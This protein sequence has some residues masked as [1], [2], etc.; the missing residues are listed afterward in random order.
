MEFK[1]RFYNA[2][3]ALL[4]NN[5]IFAEYYKRSTGNR[6]EWKRQANTLQAKEIKDWKTGV[7]TATDPE[8]PRRGDLMRFYQGLLLDNHLASVIDTRILRVQRSSFKLIDDRGTENDALKQLLER[9]WFEDLIR[10]VLMSRFQGATLIEMFDINAETLELERVDE[11]PQ[12]NFIA[13]KGLVIKEEYDDSGADYRTDAF[14]DC[15]FQVGGDWD[16]GMLNQL[17]MIVLAKKLGLGSWMSYV[18]KYGIPPIF[19]ITD[20]MD[21]GRRDELFEMLSSFRQN[22]FAVLQGNEKIEVPRIS[23]TNPHQVFLSLIDGVCNKEIS[24]RVLG[25]TATTDEK[26][27]VGSAEVQERVAADRHEA[28]KLLFRY[29]FNTQVRRRLVR[30]SSVYKDFEKYQLVW[31]NQETLNIN[32][33]IDGVQK[34]SQFFDFDVEEIRSRTGLPVTGIKQMSG[35]PAL[36]PEPAEPPKPGPQKKKPDASLRGRFDYCI[37]AAAWDAA[38]ERLVEQILSGNV[39]ASDLNRDL[40]L[41][42]YT[43]LNEAARGGWGKGYFEEELPRRLRENLLKFA[44]A[45]SYGLI[46]KMTDMKDV[47]PDRDAFTDAAKKMI[48]LHNETYQNVEN[49]FAANSAGSA[50]DFGQYVKDADIYPCLKNRTMADANVRPAH[51]VNEGV[52]KPVSEWTQTPPY[53]PGCRCWLEQTTEKP[54]GRSLNN[55]DGRWANNPAISGELFV[56]RHSYF[57]N[58]DRQDAR[59]VAANTDLMKEF[60]PYSRQVKAG[61][62][63]VFINDFADLNDLKPNIDA[64][65]IV[66][67][68]LEKDVYI[69]PHIAI[70]HGHPNPEFGIGRQ[71]ILADLKTMA[72]GSENFFRSRMK[73]AYRQNCKIV[74]M[75]IDSYKGDAVKLAAKIKDGFV[76]HGKQVNTGI[77]KILIIRNEKVIRITRKQALRGAFKELEK[78]N[79]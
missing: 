12:S 67:E 47:Y 27:F 16:L 58:I 31:D 10:L 49:R 66:A 51:A 69:R 38:T 62:N 20:R 32:G 5:K 29:V 75:N 45:K 40:V 61:E 60:M 63:S 19:A 76:R 53:D 24:K 17:A 57:T 64:A 33:Y 21:T 34:L 30:T 9:P 74:V 14:A 41:K 43:A 8:N 28:D 72:E 36:P 70:A 68:F 2:I 52:I 4:P 18:D 50:R 42:Y 1:D 65:G 35:L 48:D 78:L 3:S 13:Q 79:K 39:K 22:M 25:G 73:S 55:I 77:D 6:A 44:G 56:G 23:E 7:M 71:N 54:N 15:Y 26:S 11:I 37:F 46:R 59:E